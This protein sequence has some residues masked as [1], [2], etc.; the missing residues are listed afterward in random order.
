MP[1][2]PYHAALEALKEYRRLIVRDMV[3]EIIIHRDEF[4]GGDTR[5]AQE[6]VAKHAAR[7]NELGSVYDGVAR[8]ISTELPH[9]LEPL[10][11][12]IFDVSRAAT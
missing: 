5:T 2:S 10:A 12:M 4:K 3:N 6:I 11:R 7:L 8:F 1:P 9:G